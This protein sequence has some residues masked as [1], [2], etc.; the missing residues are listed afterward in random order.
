MQR[1][2]NQCDPQ[3]TSKCRV[4][5]GLKRLCAVWSFHFFFEEKVVAKPKK[6]ETIMR[7]IVTT[8]ITLFLGLLLV[9]LTLGLY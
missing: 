2:G 3:K 6:G 9:G 8:Y 4:G 5:D 1:G 7:A